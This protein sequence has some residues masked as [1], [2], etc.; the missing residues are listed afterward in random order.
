MRRSL[1]VLLSAC[2][3]AMALL[4]VSP[5]AQAAPA[6]TGRLVNGHAGTPAPLW[7]A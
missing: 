3:T 5:S 7:L 6:I 4:A 2:L 1:A